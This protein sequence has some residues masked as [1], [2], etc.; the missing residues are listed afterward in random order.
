VTIPG[1]TPDP[2]FIYSVSHPASV[3]VIGLGLAS[4]TIVS[5]YLVFKEMMRESDEVAAG[6]RARDKGELF[7]ATKLH[8]WQRGWC[9]RDVILERGARFNR[10]ASSGALQHD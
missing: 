4:L 2:L 10:I 1:I 5:I 7:D 8:A 3:I 6:E 9:N